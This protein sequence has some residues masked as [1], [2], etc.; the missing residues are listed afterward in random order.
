MFENSKV[1]STS[2]HGAAALLNVRL[3]S[4]KYLLTGKK[5]TSIP[6]CDEGYLIPCTENKLS[7]KVPFNLEQALQKQGGIFITN[8]LSSNHIQ[9]EGNL[10][11]SQKGL[12][13]MFLATEVKKML[14]QKIKR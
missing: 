2:G 7:K 6:F 13:T 12:S 4:G 9:I 8:S 10:I 11:S 14:A 5:I 3:S 1:I